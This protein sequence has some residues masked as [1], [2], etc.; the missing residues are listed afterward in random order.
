MTITGGSGGDGMVCPAKDVE[1]Q[2]VEGSAQFV[3][4]AA[5]VVVVVA[6]GLG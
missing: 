3:V 6:G 4:T 2:V 5:V 1:G